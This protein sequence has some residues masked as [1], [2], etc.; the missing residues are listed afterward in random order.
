MVKPTVLLLNPPGNQR[1]MRDYFC[2]KV[3]KGSYYYHP[4]DLLF[5]SGWLG[6]HYRVRVLDSVVQ[7]IGHRATL[8]YIKSLR[9]DA[10]VALTAAPSFVEDQALFRAIKSNG[11]PRLMVT[12]DLVLDHGEDL[13]RAHREIDGALLD[14][15]T[16][17][18]LDLL[19]GRP[20]RNAIYREGNGS[21]VA[22][23]VAREG[24]IFEIPRPRHELFPLEAYRFIL[25]RK[26]H[27]ATVL[28]DFGCPFPCQYCISGHLNFKLRELDGV[29][30]EIEHL[31][32]MGISELFFRDQTFGIHKD[33]TFELCSRLESFAP[34]LGWVCFS[35]TDVL[36]EER[37]DAMKEAGCHTIIF[38]LE[39]ANHELLAGFGKAIP[40][41]TTEA[42]LWACARRGIRTLGTFIL[43]LPGEDE[44]AVR[45]TIQ[46]ATELPVDFATFNV[47]TPRMGTSLRRL[48]LAQGWTDPNRLDLDSSCGEPA[49]ATPSL[50]P[51]RLAWL[52][53]EAVRAFYGRPAYVGRRLVRVRSWHDLY[54]LWSEGAGMFR[55]L[56]GRN[57]GAECE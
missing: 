29:M 21:I 25:S 36:D 35:R 57:V 33:R 26:R 7:G 38:G 34:R 13:L 8:A 28:S 19:D 24:G 16:P 27:F 18:I 12:G 54:S 10:V 44:E 11:A 4:V 17:D 31:H 56:F 42:T 41:E 39:T 9:P 22:T 51:E 55:G 52:R 30:E 20:S 46:W 47:A 53:L 43:G 37:L 5:L 3:S 1:I 48:A 32:S 15:S 49:I 14:F 2:S 45:R 6:D 40:K 23:P 50:S